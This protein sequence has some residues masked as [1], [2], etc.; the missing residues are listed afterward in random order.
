MRSKEGGREREDINVLISLL[1][2]SYC[3]TTLD[4]LYQAFLCS[5]DPVQ[6]H[7][8][9]VFS[10]FYLPRGLGLLVPTGT[11]GTHFLQRQQFCQ[12]SGRSL[13]S[14]SLCKFLVLLV[15]SHILS[16]VTC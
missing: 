2:L 16:E 12:F 5:R 14:I 7:T 10:E 1:A 13:A 15:H 11:H 4:T 8:R 9:S 6:V 3:T